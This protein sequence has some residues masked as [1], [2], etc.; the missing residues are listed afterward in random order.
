MPDF[1]CHMEVQ[2]LKL[3]SDLVRSF[4]FKYFQ[5]LLSENWITFPNSLLKTIFLRT[6]VFLVDS[7]ELLEIWYIDRWI[8]HVSNQRV[9]H[10]TE[11]EQAFWPKMVSIWIEFEFV[12][13]QLPLV[14][15]YLSRFLGLWFSVSAFL[16][17]CVSVISQ[18]LTAV[19]L[20]FAR[21]E[22]VFFLLLL[23]F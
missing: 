23:A 21:H 20:P 9:K 6:Q 12:V 13:G 15:A 5:H 19:A 3:Q 11:T 16:S 22:D 17:F 4:E 1:F 14:L 10:W 8:C 18:F 2:V 7:S